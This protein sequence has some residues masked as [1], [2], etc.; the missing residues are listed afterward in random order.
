M[1]EVLSNRHG[2][3]NYAAALNHWRTHGIHEGRIGSPFFNVKYYKSIH[4]DLTN[5]TN[6]EAARHW[7]NFGIKEGRQGSPI[8]NHGWYLKK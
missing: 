4:S 6:E 2:I 8:F 3:D 5:M 7:M 1:Y